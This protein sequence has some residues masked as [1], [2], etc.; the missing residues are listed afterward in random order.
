VY[1]IEAVDFASVNKVRSLEDERRRGLGGVGAPRWSVC[2]V[3]KEYT[4]T[5]AYV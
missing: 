1:D 5:T 4:L 3:L 2:E